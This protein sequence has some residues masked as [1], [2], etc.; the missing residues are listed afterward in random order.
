VEVEQERM[1][2]LMENYADWIGLQGFAAH[3]AADHRHKLAAFLRFL[4]ERNQSVLEVDAETIAAYQ[5]HIFELISSKTGK[6]LSCNTQIHL[7]SGL[8]T[9]YRFLRE[10]KRVAA[11][12]TRTLKLPRE[13]KLL[14]P[15]I[16]KPREMRRLLAAPDLGNPLGYRD[17]VMMEV[18]YASGIR[19]N[20]LLSLAVIDLQLEK[21]LIDI[22][23][24]KGGKQRLVPMGAACGNWLRAYL[25]EVRPHLVKHNGTGAFAADT[26]RVFLNRFGRPMDKSGWCKKLKSYLAAAR[27]EKPF[28]THCFRHQLATNM[29]QRGA[30]TRHIQK[31]LGHDTLKTT[32]RY[33]QV[34]KAE[35]KRIH[36]K[37]HP[38]G[39]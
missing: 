30:D 38:R 26:G 16:L 37:T 36:R 32:Q 23:E 18:F 13:P 12:P 28:T 35:L 5:T 21:A 29:L 6:R 10:T 22:R 19:L 20:E 9:F 17:R 7:L 31:L 3:S 39:G 15:V 33:L 11:D 25:D 14:P 1:G 2:T 24:G 8:R 27:I 4:E 34:V